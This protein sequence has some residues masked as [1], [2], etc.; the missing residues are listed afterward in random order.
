MNEKEFCKKITG[1]VAPWEIS[2]IETD[3]AKKR[4]DVYL[5]Y[6]KGK[7]KCP[8][9]NKSV[10]LYDEREERVWRHLDSCEYQTYLHCR[11][12]RSNCAEHGIKTMEV[13]WSTSLS[14]FTISFERHAIDL[15]QATKNRSKSAKLLG[16]SWDEINGIMQRGV[17]RGLDRRSSTPIPY[18]SID[19]KSFLSG[20]SYVSVL[21]DP[22]GKRV[23]DVVEGRDIRAVLTLFGCLNRKQRRAVKAVSMDFWKAFITVVSKI[24]PAHKGRDKFHIMKYI[25]EAVNSIRASE[26]KWRAKQ[27][28]AILTGT[29]YL[30]LKRLEN[31]TDKDKKKWAELN[32]DQLEVGK[33]WNLREL[34]NEFWNCENITSARKFFKSWYYKVTHSGLEPMIKVAEMIKRHFE[35]IIT[36]WRHQIS[37]G[38]AEGINSVIQEI[39]TVARGF[40]NFQNY[41]TAMLFFLWK[42]RLVPTR[43]SVEPFLIRLQLL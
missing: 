18:L 12:P 7:G 10:P 16:I 37:N 40:R 3:E 4:V 25:N 6:S 9:C 42:I 8:E 13:P 38:Y 29:K 2:K 5:D 20:Q 21:S 30:W 35:N 17:A 1:V 34:F 11:M 33:A 31:F 32:L 43:K 15:L 24:L 26:H 19:E 39:K 41:R 23:L 22:V 27:K 36:W 14:R 28:D